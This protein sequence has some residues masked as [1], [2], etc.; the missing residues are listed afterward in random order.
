MPT[1]CAVKLN[2][3]FPEVT[4]EQAEQ[5]LLRAKNMAL[6]RALSS[7]KNIDKAMEEVTGGMIQR[8]KLFSA[9]AKRATYLNQAKEQDT[10]DFVKRFPEKG[11]TIGDGLHAYAVGGK[12]AVEG[13]RMSIDVQHKT[14]NEQFFGRLTHEMEA[15]G[16]F[17]AF[18]KNKYTKEIY[19][20]M[21]ELTPEGKPG[22]SG[23][24]MAQKI[25]AIL[26]RITKEMNARLNDAGALIYN[27]PGYVV[28][29]THDMFKIRALG[30]T[31]DEA[32]VAWKAF[33]APLVDGEKTFL[34]A[35]KDKFLNMVFN[36]LYT[37]V[38]GV[39]GV[40]GQGVGHR[41]IADRWQQERVLHFKNAE[42][43]WTYN[44]K[45]GQRD[46]MQ[47]VMTDI[48]NKARSIAL[49]ENLGPNAE[50]S[51]LNSIRMLKEWARERPDAAQ[52]IDSINEHEL[53]AY[54]HQLTGEQD[55]PANANLARMASNVR[56]VTQMAKMGGVALT[57]LFTD[58]A[59]MHP[60]MAYQ[61]I[62]HLQTLGKQLTMLAKKTPE[63]KATLRLMGVGLDGLLG[64][65]LSRYSATGP[66]SG[67]INKFQKTFFDINF[68]NPITDATK[69]AAAELMSTHLGNH[70]ELNFADLPKDLNRVLSLYDIGAKE[71]NLLRSTAYDHPGS[72]WGK[73]ITADQLYKITDAQILTLHKGEGIPS[74]K[75]II[76]MRERLETQL[77][78]YITDQTS[79]AV[80]TP[81]GAERAWLTLDTKGG[82]GL[83]EAIRL[84]TLFKSFPVT[85]MNRIIQREVYGRGAM[86]AKQWLMND[87]QGKF[88]L[89]QLV[90]MTT[91]AGYLGMTIRDA[92]RGRT[93]REL[94]TDGK[95]NI[96]VLTD[97]AVQGG[98]LGI[99]GETVARDYGQGMGSFLENATGPVFGQLDK[100]AVM[101]TKASEG[102]NISGDA[103][104]MA[105]DNTPL[106]NLFYA[107]PILNYF[108]LWNLQ[109]MMNPGSLK[110][111][112]ENVRANNNQDFFVTPSSTV[113]K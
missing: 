12:Y 49:M 86:S 89:A 37:G 56:A 30:K 48:G 24:P 44:E 79:G 73:V 96:G 98:G 68:S 111:T 31:M 57:N 67:P 61:G 1:P 6:E 105:L 97:A 9:N 65:I 112:E 40:E 70:A 92:L 8:D 36:D 17:E 10:Q 11:L 4:Q 53:M 22:A 23:N 82:T 94:I 60:G 7:G 106:I 13:S 18:W 109:E 15:A 101:K 14:L 75:A 58:N 5:I 64:N 90:A 51:W 3:Q 95:I 54:F 104:K 77:R 113:N 102:K 34:G 66:I 72:N 28:R 38:K 88:N 33:V 62:G 2:E 76:K 52:Q 100:L 39:M 27:L 69:S 35:D 29:Q 91:V 78:S 32:R 20:E 45:L 108:V 16:V 55:I 84:L 21:G 103:Y 41:A 74:A 87:H 25:A 83:G 81:G 80:P 63:E 99:M 43:A 42:S 26:D 50:A 46:F 110:K 47:Q 19:Q 71:W 85:V 59:F 93:P 107:R